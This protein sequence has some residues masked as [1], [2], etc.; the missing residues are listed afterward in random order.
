MS[1]NPIVS[2]VLRKQSMSTSTVTMPEIPTYIKSDITRIAIIQPGCWGDNIN[3]TLMLKPLKDRYINSTIDILTTTSYAFAFYNNPLIDKIIEFQS[4]SKNHALDHM[5]R[6]PDIIQHVG[7][8]VIF[9]PHPMRNPDKW[10]SI[11]HGHLG[12][13]L[14]CAWVRALEE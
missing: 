9:N 10:T 6:I 5:F 11:H 7:Y 12:T 4:T 2:C 8:D 3:S 14:I 1:N 13:N